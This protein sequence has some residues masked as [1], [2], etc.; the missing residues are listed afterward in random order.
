MKRAFCRALT[1][2]SRAPTGTRR[3]HRSLRHRDSPDLGPMTA[4]PPRPSLVGLLAGNDRFFPAADFQLVAIGIFKEAGVIAG[5]V[6]A[7][8]LRAFQIFSADFAHQSGDPIDFCAALS[9]ESDSS[10]VASMPSILGESE[11]CFRSI[12]ACGIEDSEPRT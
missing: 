7:A 10:G 5:A 3:A 11:E 12:S 4:T 8:K 2:T 6:A 1:H 9:P